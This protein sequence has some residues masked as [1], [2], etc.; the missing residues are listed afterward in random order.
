[1]SRITKEI[2]SEVALKLIS[3]KSDEIIKLDKEISE[4]FEV[5]V[6]SKLPRAVKETFKSNKVFFNRRKS[7]QISGNGF[8]Y[9]Y[10][11]TTNEVP[12][13]NSSFVATAEESKILLPMVNKKTELEVNYRKLYREIETLLYSLRT[14]SKVIAEF[15]EAEPFLPAS[16]SNKLMLNVSD[17]RKQLK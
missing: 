1:M 2:A 13:N 15:P 6:L 9:V 5:M 16:I 14:Y 3:K 4:I 10:V 7:F 11:N 17:I 8:D 12:Y